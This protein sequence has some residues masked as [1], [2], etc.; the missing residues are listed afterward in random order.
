MIHDKLYFLI[1]IL[2]LIL[3]YFM[4]KKFCSTDRYCLI[5]QIS[6]IKKNRMARKSFACIESCIEKNHCKC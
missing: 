4:L 3:K 6:L 1:E 5:V 2:M